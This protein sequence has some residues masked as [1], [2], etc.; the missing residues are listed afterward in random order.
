MYDLFHGWKNVLM[1]HYLGHVQIC[2]TTIYYLL[3]LCFPKNVF[4]AQYV[5]DLLRYTQKSTKYLHILR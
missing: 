5:Q 4:Y 3:N 1:G 2:L